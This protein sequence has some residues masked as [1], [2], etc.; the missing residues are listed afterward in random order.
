MNEP[1]FQLT[2]RARQAAKALGISPRTLWS[3]TAPRGPIP[4]VRIGRG[5]RQSVMYPIA[6][7]QAW[8][9]RQTAKPEG[10]GD[11]AR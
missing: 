2:L 4:C 5:K 9:A 6:E 1:N 8:L 3:L 11:D 10:G 7:L